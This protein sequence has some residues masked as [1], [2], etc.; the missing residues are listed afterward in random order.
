MPRF[1]EAL[2]IEPTS[3]AA[4][5][6]LANAYEKMSRFEDAEKTCLQ[7]IGLRPNYW[8]GYNWLGA[9][10]IGRER[11]AE[12]EK[13]FAQVVALS[14]VNARGYNNLGAALY[15]Q[16]KVKE[17]IAAYEKSLAIRPNASALSNL[18]TLY[19]FEEGD[20]AR[21]AKTF[22]QAVQMGP[23]DYRLW[24]NLGDARK[25]SGDPEGM[26]TAYQKALALAEA[27]RQLDPRNAQVLADLAAYHASLGDTARAGPLMQRALKAA[28]K[29]AS[30]LFQAAV[31]NELYLKQRDEALRLLERALREGAPRKEIERSPGLAELRADP[32]Y[33][34]LL[35]LK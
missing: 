29:N 22:E 20:Y 2:E 30:V 33:R 9:F 14:P 10:Y 25:W 32:R 26:R 34:K 11:H 19:F 23:D 4:Y 16:G 18:G 8:A 27:A 31:L 6:G 13:Q 35:P 17:A 1:Q 24:G 3:D 28:P 5:L 12:A 21:A 15:F 7:A